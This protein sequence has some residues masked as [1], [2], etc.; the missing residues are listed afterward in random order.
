MLTTYI[1]NTSQLAKVHARQKADPG[2]YWTYNVDSLPK[3]TN[4][5][6]CT[7]DRA[8]KHFRLSFLEHHTLD[9]P[10]IIHTRKQTKTKECKSNKKARPLSQ[11]ARAWARVLRLFVHRHVQ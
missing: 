1:L 5:R 6:N 3:L 8:Q 11:C 7:N 2:L 10:D 4:S 9:I